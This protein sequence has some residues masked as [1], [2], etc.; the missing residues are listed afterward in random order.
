MVRL[1]TLGRLDVRGSSEESLAAV[2]SR[3]R[4]MALLV[5]LATAAPGAFR[6][7]DTVLAMFWPETPEDRARHT[8]NQ[9]LY[10]LRQALG[11]EV[12]VSHGQDEIGVSAEHLQCDIMEF[13]RALEEKRWENAL[14]LY[15]GPFL[16]GFFVSN[17]PDMERW[18]E[19]ERQDHRRAARDAA[20]ALSER[21]EKSGEIQQ[22]TRWARRAW[23]VEPSSE[24]LLRRLMTLLHQM[25]ERSE[26][27][28][29]FRDFTHRL[30]E[31]YGLEP[32]AETVEL[33]ATIRAEDVTQ[34]VDRTVSPERMPVTT[35]AQA[36]GRG[37]GGTLAGAGATLLGVA[38]VAW[39]VLAPGS[40]TLD[41]VSVDNPVPVVVVLPVVMTG[42]AAPEFEDLARTLTSELTA[43]LGEIPGLVVVASDAVE[44]HLQT[45]GEAADIGRHLRG[46]AVVESTFD[47]SSTGVETSAQV[48]DVQTGDVVWEASHDHPYTEILSAQQ[49]LTL[50]VA[51]AL[52][53]RL[54]PIPRRDLTFSS[55]AELEAWSLVSQAREAMSEVRW[56]GLSSEVEDRVR[57][58][59]ERAFDIDPGYAPAYAALVRLYSRIWGTD[60]AETGWVDSA[61]VAAERVMSL[62]PD[63]FES[64]LALVHAMNIART[65]A[66]DRYPPLVHRRGAE[67]ALRAVQLNP[68]SWEAASAVSGFIPGEGHRFIW[69][70]RAH[71]LR[72]TWSDMQYSRGR[73]FYLFGDYEAGIEAYRR[74]LD[75][76]PESVRTRVAIARAY[77][78]G[79]Q[80]EL[81]RQEIDAVRALDLE[82]ALP[83]GVDALIAI[84]EQRYGVA[85]ELI[86]EL[87][88]RD[89]PVIRLSDG[90]SNFHAHTALGYVYLKT[91]RVREGTRLLELAR[92]A[93]LQSVGTGAGYTGHYNLVRLNAMLGDSDRAIQ[94]LEIAF[95]RGWTW[96]NTEVGFGDPMLEN[97]RGIEEFERVMGDLKALMAAEGDWA[98]EMLALPEPERLRRMLVDAEQQ[99]E[100]LWGG[101]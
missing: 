28:G 53:V 73:A 15:T 85:E 14:A 37:L 57:D 100:K 58:L 68:S 35:G 79:G 84:A 21:L 95:D 47:W 59:I 32:G 83:I 10:E 96:V 77:L 26:A 17:A 22:A 99:L 97:L 50:G 45:G 40:T 44:S 51:S 56:P 52:N 93:Q 24:A 82:L 30:A 81:A 72:R 91:G 61:V 31:D 33:V 64:Q 86:E 92:E 7:R 55:E 87:L 69:G 42:E 80:L 18:I 9:M 65:A 70:Q 71:M 34:G 25:G 11:E 60:R 89:P 62:E 41:P 88:N 94:R 8:L 38:A 19:E 75:L 90:T 16:P 39:V 67:A 3:P 23:E 46:D 27:L 2:T 36:G 1:Q 29:L 5:Y 76:D 54:A 20:V 6:R 66:P 101:V 49:D 12:L 43:R 74:V 4:E 13:R 63:H 78:A 98:M 48:T